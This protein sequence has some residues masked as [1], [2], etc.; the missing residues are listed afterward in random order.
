M[1]NF[2]KEETKLLLIYSPDISDSD[3]VTKD[4]EERQEVKLK[5]GRFIFQKEDLLTD[6][7]EEND[8]YHFV[9]GSIENGEYYKILGRKLGISQKIFIYKEMPISERL[10]LVPY[11]IS[12]FKKINRLTKEDIYIGGTHP[13]AIP[14]EDFMQLIKNFPNS[15]ELQKYTKARLAAV[16]GNYFV[17]AAD[18]QEKYNRYMDNKPSIEG[19]NLSQ[20][21]KFGEI[22]KYQ[23]ALDKLEGMLYNS[24]SYIEKQW[25]KEIIQIVLLLFPKYVYVLEE[26]PV[27]DLYKKKERRID[28]LLV[29]A[30]GHVDIIEIKRPFEEKIMTKNSY[31]DNYIPSRELSGTVMQIEKYI[32]HL[33]KSGKKGEEK[34]SYKYV[35]K[36]PVDFTIRIVNPRGFII[37]GRE[38]GLSSEQK[39]D[40]E[41]VKRK[42]KNVVDIITYD[43]MLERL[44]R[45]VEAWKKR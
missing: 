3:W 29:D 13:N 24:G 45:I 33:S 16:L 6:V 25:Q 43:D 12:I 44:R 30:N 31:R 34:L 19:D 10:F 39:D 2:K 40:F 9:F 18:S 1:I 36:L 14:K 11:K 17:S 28:I 38:E 42:Y 22:V 15:Y 27:E 35:D 37:M 20:I 4:I 41:V 7:R 26:A 21:F 32:Y 8:V 5:S 23:A